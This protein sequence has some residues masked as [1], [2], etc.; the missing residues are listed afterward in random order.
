MNTRTDLIHPQTAF[1]LDGLFRE[2]VRRSPEAPAYLRHDG[3]A[4]VTVTWAETA[5]EVERWRA[6]LAAEG[7]T[8]GARVALMLRNRLEWVLLDQAALAQ[9]LV[10]VPLYLEDRPEN[11]AYILEDAGAELLLVE[12]AEQWLA[13]GESLGPGGYLKR[14]VTLERPASDPGDPRLLP[15][16]AWLDRGAALTPEPVPHDAD[17]LA[18]LVYTS[19]TTGRPKGVM[20][21]HANLLANAAA[22]L[23]AAP[24]YPEDR[25]LSFLPLSHTLERTVGYYLPMM[26]GASVAHARSIPQLAED[27]RTVKPTLI[28][29]VPRVFEKVHERVTEQLEEKPAATQLLFRQALETGWRHFLWRQGRGEWHPDLLAWPLLDHMVGRKVRARLGG[30]LRLAVCGGAALPPPVSRFFLALDVPVVQGYGLTE[31]SPVV[32]VN[33]L[34]ANRP[35]T[36]GPPLPGLEVRIG[37][38]EELLVRG[39][40]VMQGYWQRPQESAEVLDPEG[41]LH[42]GDTAALEGEHLRITGRLKEIIVLDNGEKVPPGDLELALAEE[43]LFGQLMVVGEGRPWLALVAVVAPGPWAHL[44]DEHDFDP[45]DPVALTRTS[46]VTEALRRADACLHRFP[47]YARINGVV[48]SIEPWT[49]ENGLLTPT[50]KLRR[51]AVERRFAGALG[52]LYQEHHRLRTGTSG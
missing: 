21:S 8:R 14:V 47:G 42:T 52:A 2:R 37:E 43:P 29:A 22:G 39:P 41:W 33:R 18:T 15:L 38:H 12:D 6:A 27:L 3:S 46:I 32:S 28:I 45:A 16:A 30:R 49:V 1:T 36:V 17:A 5:V 13:I 26:A 19:G 31:A 20:L 11:A 35:E 34:E 51:T 44:A 40:S 50:M 23:G 7:L 25:L 10:V 9:G 48:L 4:W 24:V